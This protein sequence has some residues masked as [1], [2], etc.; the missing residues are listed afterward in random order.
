M[1]LALFEGVSDDRS[2]LTKIE[3]EFY[4]KIC[5]TNFLWEICGKEMLQPEL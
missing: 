1:V 4:S 5:V 2:V 3:N